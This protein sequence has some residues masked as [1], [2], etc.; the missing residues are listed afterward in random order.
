MSLEMSA[1]A[2]AWAGRRDGVVHLASRRELGP[3]S[4]SR[5]DVD[6]AQARK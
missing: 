6:E 2:G 4:E 5:A 1:I 3:R